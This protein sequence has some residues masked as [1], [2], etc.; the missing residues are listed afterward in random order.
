[1]AKKN[2]GLDGVVEKI[3]EKTIAT[4][5]ESGQ[6]PSSEDS[7]NPEFTE[8]PP[9]SQVKKMFS[10]FPSS[11]G[12]YGKIWKVKSD[13]IWEVKDYKLEAP[14]SVP[15]LELEVSRIVKEKGW[16]SGKYVVQVQQTGKRGFAYNKHIMIGELTPEE[17]AIEAAG[18]PIVER[19]PMMEGLDIVDKGLSIVERL[20]P[21][22]VDVAAVMKETRE[23]MKEGRTMSGGDGKDS[24][25]SVLMQIIPMVKDLFP[26][27]PQSD[28]DT[29]VEKV[30]TRLQLAQPKEDFFQ[31]L[32]KYQ[33]AMNKLNPPEKRER[34]IDSIKKVTDIVQAIRPL[35]G[36]A[37]GEPPS[38][39]QL[40]FEH[41][42][43]LLEPIISTLKEF[44]EA[45]KLEM[46]IRIDQAYGGG[47]QPGIE[48][49][50]INQR[51]LPTPVVHP[52]VLRIIKAMNENDES[53]FDMMRQQITRLYG[54]HVIDGLVNGDLT[55]DLVIETLHLELGMPID[56][57]KLKPYIEKF[58]GY[59]RGKEG[60]P[61]G[62]LLAE[63]KGCHQQFEFTK[64]EWEADDKKCDEC[65]GDIELVKRE[66][67]A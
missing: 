46:Q 54:V 26:K 33:E 20:K 67:Q 40:I 44:A 17:K 39:A 3:V 14:E 50:P 53:Y 61:P 59:L 43:K 30:V 45:K 41:G 1:M 63:C 38:V 13:G 16:G 35:T 23:A 15:D 29:I 58:I 27:A 19:S 18:K 55:S 2:V 57:P 51:N 8:S 11:E 34:E 22:P 60:L 42:A 6:I 21:A 65:S 37:A 5:Q 4:M 9:T 32:I 56:N 62:L 28:V 7:D 10:S 12:Y 36:G 66:G 47:S 48:K 31:S 64:E 25:I 52:F 49:R 24:A